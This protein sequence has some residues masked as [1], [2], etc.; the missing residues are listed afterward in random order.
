MTSCSMS[1]MSHQGCKPFLLLSV[2]GCGMMSLACIPGP[3]CDAWAT[4]TQQHIS[5]EHR[6][7]LLLQPRLPC[8][9][10]NRRFWACSPSCW[11]PPAGCVGLR[12]TLD[13]RLRAVPGVSQ[14]TLRHGFQMRVCWKSCQEPLLALPYSF[15]ARLQGASP[16]VHH[17]LKAPKEEKRDDYLKLAQALLQKQCASTV[18][19]RSIEFLL[20]LCT[21]LEYSQLPPLPWYEEVVDPNIQIQVDF[22]GADLTILSRLLPAMRFRAAINAAM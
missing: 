14:V 3:S 8:Q 5:Q 17:V 9:S 10:Y 4:L 11:Q 13:L 15:L 22:I 1:L 20:D 16:L 19:Q 6:C 21:K 2:E 12:K 18:T 7:L